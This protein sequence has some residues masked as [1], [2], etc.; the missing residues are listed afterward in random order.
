MDTPSALLLDLDGTLVDSE[1]IHRAAYRS[2]F[3]AR[4]WAYDEDTLGL[5]TG[6]RADDVFSTEPGPWAGEPPAAL[7]AEVLTHLDPERL[8]EPVPGVAELVDAV[9]AAGVP[10]AVVTSAD[11]A[12]VAATVDRLL[13]I[14]ERFQVVV[15]R[16]DVVDGK[17]H[18]ECY[19]LACERLEVEAPRAAAVEDSPA[20]VAAAVAAGVGRV[21]GVT[22]TWPREAL[23]EAGATEV[24]AD[25]R[26]LARL[27]A[28]R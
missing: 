24:I 22:T 9:V 2:F 20:G 12:W 3:A 5:F 8:P 1:P 6:R 4:G 7:H 21:Y 16:E 17:P 23:D 15:T 18:P 26:P 25:L 10:L 27:F 14:R 19:R 13:G 11:L 28:P